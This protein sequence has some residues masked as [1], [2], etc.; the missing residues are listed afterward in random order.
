MEDPQRIH[1]SRSRLA[2]AAADERRRFERALHDGVEQDL[3]ALLVRLQLLRRLLSGEGAEASALLDELQRDAHTALERVRSLA[4]DIYPALLDSRGLADTLHEAARVWGVTVTIVANDL[5]RQPREVEQ[6]A[7]FCCH[8]ILEQLKP[9]DAAHVQ[10]YEEADELALV[11]SGGD[12]RPVAIASDLA[13]AAGGRLSVR[14]A[15]ID[16][17]L[18]TLSRSRPDRKSPP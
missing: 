8:A 13:E 11:V 1:A 5:R 18:P 16:V 10:L 3:T 14:G 15:T 12:V 17:R 7:Y 9:G 4:S 6:A 2:D